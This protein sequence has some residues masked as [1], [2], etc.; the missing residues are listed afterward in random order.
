MASGIPV[1]T[2]N[3]SSLP[4][5][6]AGIAMCVDPLD[7]TTLR[8]GLERLLEDDAW[9]SR[10]AADGLAHAAEFPWS[11]CVD[12]TVAVYREIG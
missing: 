1:L 6:C 9:R 10:S 2:S 8:D 11:R 7:E 4:E 3:V 12:E 5:I